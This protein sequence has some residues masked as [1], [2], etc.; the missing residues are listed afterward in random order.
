MANTPLLEVR[1]L[2][3]AF[4]EQEVLHGVDF[5]VHRGE[6]LALVG[7]SGS[8]KSIASAAIMGLL[9]RGGKVVRGQVVHVP[10]NTVWAA[11]AQRHAAPLGKGVS[12]V[13]QDPMSSLNPSMRVGW[14]VAEVLRVHG[15]QAAAEA[16][17]RAIELLRE[18]ELPVP[19]ETFEKYPHALSGGQ[20]QRVMIALALAAE[21]EL[22]IAD[23]PTTAL[24]ATVQKSI[25]DLLRRLQR[26]R[27]LAVVFITHD[28][29]VVHAIADRAVVMCKG[30]VVETGA[31]A[32]V[33]NRPQHPY[34][35][36][37]VAARIPTKHR[38]PRALSEVLIEAK[39]LTKTYVTDATWW[40]RPRR[41]FHAVHS[42]SLHIKRG[43][44]V[45]LIGESGSGK[46]TLG[47]LLIGMQAPTSG[48]IH[49]DGAPLDA[50]DENSMARVRRQAQ[51]VFQDPYS[52]LNP[53]LTVGE[54]LAEVARNRGLTPEDS[55]AMA[56][57][58]LEEVGL[59]AADV[60]KFPGQFSGGQRQRIVIARALAVEPE[61][62]VL[63][64]S[65]AALDVH[66]QREI[67]ALLAHLGDRRNL[68]YLFISHDLAVVA[69]FC[70]RLVI[71]RNGEVVEAGKTEEI[72]SR[73]ASEYTAEL[74]ASR[75]GNP[76]AVLL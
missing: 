15:K 21:P 64:E 49:F 63:D 43:E 36:Q 46:S 71:L 18:V 47:R 20:K 33:L 22:L 29:D 68:T 2:T 62:L 66:I 53:K 69:S 72:L 75:P 37:L 31:V 65:V 61:F 54:A 40:G 4:G 28:L 70:D 11:P 10:S 14:Q 52:A 44:R 16:R 1:Q 12:M 7:E 41:L 42:V 32:D 51:L 50:R 3:V 8:G 48:T 27:Q 24:D 73:P 25:L 56:R 23:E 59:H 5:Q 19:A 34:T 58:L 45:G 67:L 57:N 26:D 9:P 60:G 35:Q 74:L 13:F 76:S 38:S 30:H 55:A 6:I 39:N 17:K